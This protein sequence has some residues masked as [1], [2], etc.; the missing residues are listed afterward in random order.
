MENNIKQ[1]NI[2][3]ITIDTSEDILKL[4]PEANE[5]RLAK[6]EF[7]VNNDI[8]NASKG[9]RIVFGLKSDGKIVGTM[10]LIFKDKKDFYADGKIKAHVHHARVMDGL[11]GKGLGSRLLQH[12]EIE[13]AKRGFGELTL[14]VEKENESAIIFYEKRGFK[15]FMRE[16]GDEGEIIIGMKKNII[17]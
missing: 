9:E 16:K 5:E 6:I 7:D 1:G 10:Q 11:R 17:L 12:I 13:A 15:E 8:E 4:Y 2:E 14:G 3:I